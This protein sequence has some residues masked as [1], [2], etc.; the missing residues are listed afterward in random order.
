M[1]PVAPHEET[2]LYRR[3]RYQNLRRQIFALDQAVHDFRL[4]GPLPADEAR[5][6]RKRCRKDNK[7]GTGMRPNESIEPMH[8]KATLLSR[9]FG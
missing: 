6:S 2:V 7:N 9:S 5:L 8:A 4:H 1:K 3:S